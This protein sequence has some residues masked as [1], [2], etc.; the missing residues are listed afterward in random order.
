MAYIGTAVEYALHCLLW[1]VEPLSTPASSGDLAELQGVP[2]AFLAKILPKL[3]R[4]RI[5]TAAEGA[6]GGYRLE[7][8]PAGIT[9]LD[10]VEAI[11]GRKPLFDCQEIRGRC[12]LFRD[13]APRW[14]TSGICSIHAVMVRAEEV[15][16]AELART[17]LADLARTVGRKAPAG[18]AGDVRAWLGERAALRAS[19]GAR[20]D[21][22]WAGSGVGRAPA[23]RR[24]VR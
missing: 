17:T 8:P 6:R 24:K 13:G 12:A 10:V 4:A 11:E 19:R 15:L 16:R 2:A 3:E 18:F 9:V 23:P 20:R 21:E 14:A 22:E 1:L 7:R 5:V